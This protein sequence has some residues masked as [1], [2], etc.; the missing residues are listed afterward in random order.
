MQRFAGLPK[1]PSRCVLRCCSIC[2]MCD[3]TECVLAMYSAHG[4]CLGM[5][6]AASSG[7]GQVQHAV[8]APRWLCVCDVVGIRWQTFKSVGRAQQNSL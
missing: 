6:P 3:V 1:H 7:L 8:D 4:L 5:V 2:Q